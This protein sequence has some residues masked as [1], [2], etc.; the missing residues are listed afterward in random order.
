MPYQ[1]WKDGGYKEMVC[2]YGWQKSEDGSCKPYEWM[3]DA[4][5]QG[6]YATPEVSAA[7]NTAV[8]PPAA[9]ETKTETMTSTYTQVCILFG[10]IDYRKLIFFSLRW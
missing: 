2:G 5:S 4:Y 1:S 7:L 8:C 10:R 6:C 9:T 3:P